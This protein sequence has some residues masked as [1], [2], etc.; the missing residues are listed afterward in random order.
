[1]TKYKLNYFFLEYP[2]CGSN[3][4]EKMINLCSISCN[5][6]QNSSSPLN[7]MVNLRGC[8]RFCV[9]GKSINA[10]A[11]AHRTWWWSDS[12]LLTSSE[13]ASPISCWCCVAKNNTAWARLCHWEMNRGFSWPCAAPCWLARSGWSC[14][15]LSGFR[16]GSRKTGWHAARIAR[17]TD[18]PCPIWHRILPE[19]FRPLWAS[20]NLTDAFDRYHPTIGGVTCNNEERFQTNPNARQ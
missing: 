9:I 1:M 2:V 19:A 18:S 12:A 5:S 8:A 17:S 11:C 20:P 4:C 3:F 14:R 16:P 10:A 7:G 13:S 15:S 6:Q